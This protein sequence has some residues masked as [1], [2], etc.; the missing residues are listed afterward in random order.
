MQDIICLMRPR[1]FDAGTTIV[2]RGDKVDQ[3]MLLKSGIIDV[4]VPVFQQ[5]HVHRRNASFVSSM[6]SEGS[7]LSSSRSFSK[8][9]G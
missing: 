7:M 9:E 3:L 1:R 5:K 6:S 2:K 4:Q 8:R